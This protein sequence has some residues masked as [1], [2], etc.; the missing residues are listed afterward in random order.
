MA[1]LLKLEVDKAALVQRSDFTIEAAHKL[2]ADSTLSK[3][4]HTDILAR[5]N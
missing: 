1:L 3:L 2:F 4:C 5:L